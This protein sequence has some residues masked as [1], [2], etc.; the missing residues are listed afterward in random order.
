MTL[1]RITAAPEALRVEGE[2]DLASA[3]QLAEALRTAIASEVRSVDVSGVTFLD[4]TGLE[5][6]LSAGHAMNGDGPL[7]LL[8]PS[9][10]VR[11][12]LDIAL[13]GGVPALAVR[14]D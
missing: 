12:L 13:P 10:P 8:R 14:D 5:V 7:V 1:L 11:R 4:S 9:Y 3:D 6:L 2:I